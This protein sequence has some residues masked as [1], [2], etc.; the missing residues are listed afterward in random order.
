MRQGC[1]YPSRILGTLSNNYRTINATKKWTVLSNGRNPRMKEQ[2]LTR[3]QK[4]GSFPL[5]AA[6]RTEKKDASRQHRL[7]VAA[8]RSPDRRANGARQ[9]CCVILWCASLQIHQNRNLT[10]HRR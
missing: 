10:A 3:I 9:D 6:L 4:T 7:S 1:G 2:R 8:R 5:L